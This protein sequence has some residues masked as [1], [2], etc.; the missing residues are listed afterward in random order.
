MFGPVVLFDA[1]AKGGVFFSFAVL[2]SS[3]EMADTSLEALVM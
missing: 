1:E 3:L 2:S